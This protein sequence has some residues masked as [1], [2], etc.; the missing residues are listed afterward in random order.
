MCFQR[1]SQP[2]R[3]EG[4]GPRSPGRALLMRSIF[5]TTVSNDQLLNQKFRGLMVGKVEYEAKTRKTENKG[6]RHT[7]VLSFIVGNI[8]TT[9]TSYLL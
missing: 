3:A 2:W 1:S 7:V 9:K 8:S 5:A 6:R 4:P